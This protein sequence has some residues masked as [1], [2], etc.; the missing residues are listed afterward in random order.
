VWQSLVILTVEPC[1]SVWMDMLSVSRS[2]SM[3]T[4]LFLRSGVQALLCVPS[5]RVHI[6]GVELLGH[7][8]VQP[9]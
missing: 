8:T 4:G 7:M 2:P 3:D 6:L 9:F 1:P 5:S